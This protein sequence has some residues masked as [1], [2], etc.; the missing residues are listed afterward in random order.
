MTGEARGR[1]T[2]GVII[3]DKRY[4]PKNIESKIEQP[5]Q[6]QPEDMMTEEEKQKEYNAEEIVKDLINKVGV[7]EVK[8]VKGDMKFF[9]NMMVGTLGIQDKDRDDMARRIQRHLLHF[10]QEVSSSS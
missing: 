2:I 6:V 7:E 5:Y 1:G 10:K 4:L 8:R 9:V 3:R